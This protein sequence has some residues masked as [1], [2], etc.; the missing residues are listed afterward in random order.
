MLDLVGAHLPVLAGL[1]HAEQQGL[2]LQGEFGDLVQEEGAAVGVFE[3]ALAGFR[4]PG[5]GALHVTEEFGVHELLGEGAAVHHEEA[6]VAAVGVL[7]D[8]PGKVLLAHAAFAENHDA[9]V[10]RR[11]LHRRF[12][13]LREGRIV[14]D[15]IV[16]IFQCL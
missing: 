1:E 15:D 10:G 11:K 3:I 16:F 4:G 14:A 2:R 9:Q 6:A 7:M 5:E 8:D 12:Q 13:R